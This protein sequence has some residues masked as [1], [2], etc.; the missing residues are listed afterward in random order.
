MNPLIPSLQ[1]IIIEYCH[2]PKLYSEE[3]EYSLRCIYYFIKLEDVIDFGCTYHRVINHPKDGW[4]ITDMLFNNIRQDL[5]NRN[6]DRNEILNIGQTNYYQ[7][8]YYSY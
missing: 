8:G 7:K 3:L 4:I 2:Y 6:Y 5:K 1:K